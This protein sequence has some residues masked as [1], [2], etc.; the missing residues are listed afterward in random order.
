M[1]V[2]NGLLIFCTIVDSNGDDFDVVGVVVVGVGVVV[3]RVDT[4]GVD[5]VGFDVAVTD[6]VDVFFSF[7]LLFSSLVDM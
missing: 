7:P 4:V 6:V 3:V 2:A 5:V 1:T